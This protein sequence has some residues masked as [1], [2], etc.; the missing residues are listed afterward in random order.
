MGE[1]FSGD[2]QLDAP[3]GSPDRRRI[4]PKSAQHSLQV[5]L[6]RDPHLLPVPIRAVPGLGKVE[7]VLQ[8]QIHG[9]EDGLGAAQ[10]GDLDAKPRKAGDKI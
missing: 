4:E 6:S 10:Q 3:P 8:G 1:S 9:S 7:G 2:K 5:R